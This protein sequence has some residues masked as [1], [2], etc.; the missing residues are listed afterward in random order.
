MMG[1]YSRTEWA[2][3]VDLLLKKDWSIDALDAG[4]IDE[5]LTRHWES[6]TTPEDFVSWF[7]EKYDL[8]RFGA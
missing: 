5:D 2:C 8:I 1:V 3:A 6:G 4:L 7:S